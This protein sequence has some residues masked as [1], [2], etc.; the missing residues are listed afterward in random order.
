MGAKEFDEHGVAAQPRGVEDLAAVVRRAEAWNR[1]A[2]LNGLGWQNLFADAHGKGKEESHDNRQH[3]GDTAEPPGLFHERRDTECDG[4]EPD[5]EEEHP[6]LGQGHVLGL[7]E[8][9]PRAAEGY[10]EREQAELGSSVH[11]E[12]HRESPRPA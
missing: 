3:R 6:V 11:R 5:G 1:L 4:T 12:F 9:D 2:H 7:V 8:P 10:D